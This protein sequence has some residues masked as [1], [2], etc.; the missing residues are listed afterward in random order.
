MGGPKK[1]NYLLESRPLV[2][3]ASSTALQGVSVLG[4]HLYQCTAGVVRGCVRF[5]WNFFG[6]SFNVFAHFMMGDLWAHLPTLLSVGSFWPK[7]T[8]YPCPTLPIHLLSL[9][10]TF[11][12]AYFSVWMNKSP[13]KETFCQCGR[14]KTKKGISTERYQ[15]QRVQKLFWAVG[16]KSQ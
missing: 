7:T 11:F 4:T 6:D 9:Q 10:M 15:N 16:E 13:Q 8:W 1:N 2:V 5:Q 14:G 3:Q 12:F